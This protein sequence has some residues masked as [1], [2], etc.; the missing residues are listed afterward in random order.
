MSGLLRPYRGIMP[1]VADSAFIAETAV[2]IGDVEIGPGAS[3]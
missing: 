1:K 3:V 2:L